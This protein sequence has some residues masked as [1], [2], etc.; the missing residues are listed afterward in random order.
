MNILWTGTLQKRFPV[1]QTRI[2][3]KRQ[4]SGLLWPSSRMIV[5]LTQL[6][7]HFA[8]P[9]PHVTVRQSKSLEER[10]IGRR[11][12]PLCKALSEKLQEIFPEPDDKE[13]FV[14]LA[15]D[16]RSQ[17]CI[18]FDHRNGVGKLVLKVAPPGHEHPLDLTA[19]GLCVPSISDDALRQGI[20]QAGQ[21][22]QNRTPFGNEQLF[23]LTAP[24]LR[25]PG[26]LDDALR[27]G[28]SQAGQLATNGAVYA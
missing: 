4:M 19:S 7:V 14:V 20:S 13:F 23:D 16:A 8:V 12:A 22:A 3:N 28:I 24:D 17:I 10:E 15:L 9:I 26:I 1:S 25:V 27:Q 6:M 2:R 11:F 18:I 21:L 5:S